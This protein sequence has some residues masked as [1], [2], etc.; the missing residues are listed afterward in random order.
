MRLA[1]TILCVSSLFAIPAESQPPD[2]VPLRIAA[3]TVVTFHVQSRLRPTGGDTL[4]LLPP[5]TP[6]RVRLSERIDSTQ[7]HDGSAFRGTLV[8]QIASGGAVIH[9]DAE[10]RGIL[11]LLRSKDRPDGFRYEL[12][13]TGISEQGQAHALT[14][15]LS[16]SF[17]E[18]N[19]P[20]STT[21]ASAGTKTVTPAAK[22]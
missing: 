5:G 7:D 6:L 16:P 21:P 11:V 12:M 3:G 4:D 9:E 20:L 8:T 13:V 1:L 10:V 15:S 19:S 2:V 18:S 17:F 14:A 22:P